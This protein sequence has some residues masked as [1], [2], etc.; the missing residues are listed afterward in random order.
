MASNPY[1]AALGEHDQV[2]SM[3]EAPPSMQGRLHLHHSASS[4]YMPPRD[5]GAC[6]TYSR[7]RPGGL[8]PT[9]AVRLR[10]RLKCSARCVSGI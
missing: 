10:Q 9:P 2:K 4:I 6:V 8:A 7:I 3:G 5:S 1:A